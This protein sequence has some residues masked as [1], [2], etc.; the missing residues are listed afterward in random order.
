MTPV[1]GEE[2]E[3]LRSRAGGRRA[4]G[5]GGASN[6]IA[7]RQRTVRP[8]NHPLLPFKFEPYYTA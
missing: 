6:L 4:G 7:S 5:E 2:E 1:G 3:L 8:L